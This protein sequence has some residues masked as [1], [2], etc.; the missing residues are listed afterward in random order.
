V[1]QSLQQQVENFMAIIRQKV[2]QLAQL[3]LIVFDVSRMQLPEQ[4][5]VNTLRTVVQPNISVVDILPY[6]KK[7]D[8]FL[9]DGHFNA[10]GHAAVA[11]IL[12]NEIRH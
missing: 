3:K 1:N 7:E 9:L 10:Q 12:S 8:F 5:F 4:R 6:M 11:K 2:P